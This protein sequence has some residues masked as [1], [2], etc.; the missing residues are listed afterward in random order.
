MDKLIHL[1]QNNQ[2][3]SD[4]IIDMHKTLVTIDKMLA[5]QKTDHADI[6]VMRT[7]IAE[8]LKGK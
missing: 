1:E 5:Q 2:K 6:S 8:T 3:L 4:Q 7:I